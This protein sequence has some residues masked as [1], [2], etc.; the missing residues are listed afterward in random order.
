MI[1]KELVELIEELYLEEFYNCYYG[2]DDDDERWCFD[3][4]Q[5][6]KSVIRTLKKR[7]GLTE[8]QIVPELLIAESN[9][10]RELENI[11]N[12]ELD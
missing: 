10:I 8:D 1:G 12:L 7:Y 3:I 9:V 5:F 6:R 11:F 4:S 2:F